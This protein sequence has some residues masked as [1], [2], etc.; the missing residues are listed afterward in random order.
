[1]KLLLLQ[2][3]RKK[4]KI[5]S[6]FSKV[7]YIQYDFN[8]SDKLNLHE[9]F[10]HP[11]KLIH[12]AWEGLPNYN[13]LIHIEKNLF[14]HYVFIKNLISNGL[15]DITVAGTCFEYGI[16]G[17]LNENMNT[18]PNNAYPLAKDSL[19]KFIEEL[20]KNFEFRYKWVRLLY[21]W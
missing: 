4:L 1:M 13:D 11:N 8:N 18:Q 3:I 10:S 5:F 14:N 7:Q 6:W 9:Y 15:K 16:N 17:C 2:E 12:L 20:S 19:R 21:V